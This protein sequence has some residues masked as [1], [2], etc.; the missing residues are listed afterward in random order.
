MRIRIYAYF[1]LVFF[2]NQNSVYSQSINKESILSLSIEGKEYESLSLLISLDKYESTTIHGIR[3]IDHW[4]FIIPDS[5]YERHYYMRFIIPTNTDSVRHDLMFLVEES[6]SSISN[7]TFDRNTPIINAHYLNTSKLNKLP[8]FGY[9]DVILD[10]YQIIEPSR[11]WKASLDM[12]R[13]GRKFIRDDSIYERGYSKYLD[14]TKKHVDTRSCLSQLYINLALFKTK[15]DVQTAFNCFS[16]YYQKSYWGQKIYAYLN[17]LHFPNIQLANSSKEL[18]EYII[19]DS[20]KYNLIIFSASWCSPCHKMIPILKEVYNDLKEQ[21]LAITYISIDDPSTAENWSSMLH[22]YEIPWRSL[23]ALEHLGEVRDLYTVQGIP[24][25]YLVY[26][27]GR[28]EKIDLRKE[29]DKKKLYQIVENK[30]E[31]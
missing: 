12:L 30:K 14:L 16:D 13:D 27:N 15:K 19:A 9:K 17:D 26:P 6:K 8:A 4:N 20:T 22:K 29:A 23:M 3:E 21:D 1:I 25:S 2:L 5:I 10:S 7:F 31:P 24:L 28:F 18:S 11:E